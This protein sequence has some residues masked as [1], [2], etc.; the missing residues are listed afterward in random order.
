V[1]EA[2][3]YNLEGPLQQ[4]TSFLA[5]L[6]FCIRTKIPA[7][8]L[9]LETIFEGSK[10]LSPVNPLVAGILVVVQKGSNTK[11]ESYCCTEP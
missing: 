8:H 3:S 11:K 10:K 1:Y 7:L 4:Y 6:S 9:H 5:L 2:L